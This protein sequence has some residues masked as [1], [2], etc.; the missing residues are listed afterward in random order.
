MPVSEILQRILDTY[1]EQRSHAPFPGE[2][3]PVFDRLVEATRQLPAVAA[4]PRLLVKAGFGQG[5]WA[6]M[7]W[8]M[9]ADPREAVGP[10]KG[11]MC[12]LK[13]PYDMSGVYVTLNQGIDRVIREHGDSRP[14]ARAA[15]RRAAGQIRERA[16]TLA[17]QG[18]QLGGAIDLKTNRRNPQLDFEASTIAWKFYPAEQLPDDATLNADVE[19]LLAVYLD[20]VAERTATELRLD[21]EAL[22]AMKSDFLA[23]MPDFRSFAEPGKAYRYHER[24]QKVALTEAFQ[25]EIAP[26]LGTPSETPEQAEATCQA[27]QELLLQRK[28]PPSNAPQN[29][30]NWRYVVHLGKLRGEEALTAVRLMHE[31]LHGAGG[32]AERVERFAEGYWP[33]LHVEA[34]GQAQTRSLSTLLLMLEDPEHEIFVRTTLFNEVSERLLGHRM[35]DASQPMGADDYVQV[36]RLADALWQAFEDWGWAPRDMIDVQSFL[37]VAI[38]YK[39]QGAETDRVSP[40]RDALDPESGRRIFKIAPGAGAEYWP[41]CR[42]GGFICIGWDE[43]GDLRQ[44]PEEDVERFASY[45]RAAMGDQYTG[46]P[47]KQATGTRK[48]SELWAFRNLEPGDIVVANNGMQEVL[49]F[50]EVAEPGYEFRDER[51]GFKHIVH[52]RWDEGFATPVADL[53][54]HDERRMWGFTT[55]RELD[56]ETYR[57]LLEGR[58]GAA[59]AATDVEAEDYVATPLAEVVTLL[60]KSGL[61]LSERTIRRYHMALNSRGFVILAGLSGTG[62]TWLAEEY[63][64]AVGAAALMV[65]VAPNWTSDEDLLG[66][67]SP[68]TGDYQHTPLSAFLR[69]AASAYTTARRQGVTPRPYHFILDEMNLARV[70]HYFAKFLS[71]ME[72]RARRGAATIDLSPEERVTLPPNFYFVGTINVD[73]TTHGFADKVY[74]RAQLLEVDLEPDQLRHHVGDAPYREDLLE[75]RRILGDAAPFAFRVVDD[76]ARYVQQADAHQVSWQEAFDEAVLQKLLP[77]IRGTDAATAQRALEAFAAHCGDRFPLSASKARRMR[78]GLMATGFASYF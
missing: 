62:K 67:Q 10:Q 48:A 74:D 7:P 73:E 22:E 55:L 45:F 35:F 18:F 5:N 58:P 37:W 28:L 27:L 70:E 38:E 11:V 13:F 4:R 1:V 56:R 36:H 75:L 43:V 3:R 64:T 30:L 54:S 52:V 77:K 23:A 9:L 8:L 25:E 63:A 40:F 44:F 17:A 49:A 50:G 39:A 16:Q 20:Y 33:L 71:A 41:E 46:S 72:V 34:G 19:A 2:M 76:V 24:D 66:F 65:A 12:V 69:G 61:R 15:L 21:S 47:A 14:P 29:L 53:L 31:L 42:D 26:R 32:R 60:H 78:E 51:P 59:Q 6:D 57:A 68:L